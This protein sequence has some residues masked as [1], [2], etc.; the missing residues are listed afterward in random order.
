MQNL[1]ELVT[2]LTDKIGLIPTILG[3]LA[4]CILHLTNIIQYGI[5]I[6]SKGGIIMMKMCDIDH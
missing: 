5:L 2:K 6:I 1:L 4:F 3:G